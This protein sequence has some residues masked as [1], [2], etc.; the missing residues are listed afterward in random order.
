MFLNEPAE[1]DYDLRF[2]V[3][4]FPVRISWT[5]WL[6]AVVI[7]YNFCRYFAAL[8][9]SPVPFQGG[10]VMGI[11]PLLVVWTLCLFVSILIHELGHGGRVPLLRNS[12]VDCAL[13][14]WRLGD[15]DEQLFS[16]SFHV[17]VG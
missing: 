5:F 16:G 4:G 14:L 17:S 3:F 15:S 6:G 13:S 8:D 2:M 11:G 10:A 7:G 1:T 9:G 12:L